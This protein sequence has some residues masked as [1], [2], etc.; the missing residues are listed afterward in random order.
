MAREISDVVAL[1]SSTAAEM[2]VAISLTRA[3]V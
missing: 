1:C 3:M 2:V